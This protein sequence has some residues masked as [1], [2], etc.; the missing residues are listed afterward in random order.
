MSAIRHTA[1]LLFF[2]TTGCA[3]SCGHDRTVYQAFFSQYPVPISI[4]PDGTKVLLKTRYAADFEISVF[5]LS[6]A[7]ILGSGRSKATQLSTTWNPNG[8][9]IVYLTNPSGNEN[10]HMYLWD[11]RTW[12]TFGLDLPTTTTVMPPIRWSFDGRYLAYFVSGAGEK[13]AGLRVVDFQDRSAPRSFFATASYPDGDFAW[14]TKGYSLA[15]VSPDEHGTVVVIDPLER[16]KSLPKA[17]PIVPGGDIRDIAWSL[18]GTFLLVSV[19]APSDEHNQLRQVDL[20]SQTNRILVPAGQ[21]NLSHPRPMDESGRFAYQVNQDGQIHLNTA[22][23]S[24]RVRNLTETNEGVYDLLGVSPSATKLFALETSLVRPPQI[25]SISVGDDESDKIIL[26]PKERTK[27]ADGKKAEII[28]VTASDGLQIP[29]YVWRA[30]RVA[31]IEPAAVI[32]VH[33]GPHLQESPR[34]DAGIQLLL[35]HGISV[36][37]LNYRGSAGFGASFEKWSAP[38]LAA[39]DVLA[40]Q[41]YVRDTLLIP[42][43][44]IYLFATSWGSLV[45]GYALANWP[46]DF[47]GV[48]FVAPLV[49]KKLADGALAKTHFML[50]FHGQEDPMCGTQLAYQE[51]VRWFGRPL[52]SE[53]WRV[54]AGEG[55]VFRR[56]DS[57]VTTYTE[58]LQALEKRLRRPHL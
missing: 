17:L 21:W 25:V 8:D 52:S 34:W 2:V 26:Y 50:A 53:S 10:Y 14:S 49:N 43:D 31:G 57:W 7:K 51:L 42:V 28:R 40:A 5:D 3:A 9:A 22:D 55:H 20:R 41:R 38:D 46:D 47:A 54:F 58:I 4:S 16:E 48:I 33:G 11:L 39:K 18:D 13:K 23:L 35:S 45:G 36:I 1:T 27:G 32:R 30:D 56:T 37:V 6:N 29:A 44:R 19:R 12:K 24:G 15:F